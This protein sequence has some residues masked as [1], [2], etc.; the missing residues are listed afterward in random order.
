[1]PVCKELHFLAA[2][3]VFLRIL[4]RVREIGTL[5]VRHCTGKSIK[6]DCFHLCMYVPVLPKTFSI[7]HNNLFVGAEESRAECLS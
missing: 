7:F 5:Q 6:D 3:L 1:M 4:G 2:M